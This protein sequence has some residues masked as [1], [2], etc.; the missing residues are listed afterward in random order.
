[1]NIIV[2]TLV[3]LLAAAVAWFFFGRKEDEAVSAEGT[4]DILV[5]GGYHPASIKIKRGR[6]V[7][8]R[9]T[10]QDPSSCVE[11]VV[12][13]EFSIRQFLPMNTPTEIEITPQKTGVIPFQCG[14][15]MVHGKIEV[16]A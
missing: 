12:I 1:M 16:E 7:T 3:T 2:N 13:P 10:R 4:I 6:P 5:K 9:F 8:L 15:G 14:M 11:E